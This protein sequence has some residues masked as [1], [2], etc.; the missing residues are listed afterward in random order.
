M[1]QTQ[2]ISL[3][4]PPWYIDERFMIGAY[5]TPCIYNTIEE[6]PFVKIGC[7]LVSRQRLP[8]IS[9]SYPLR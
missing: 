8:I 4:D 7:W 2:V 9:I 6:H 3:R 1:D 5:Y